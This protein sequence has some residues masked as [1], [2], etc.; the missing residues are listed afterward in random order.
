M[1]LAGA[2]TT[3]R[4]RF[5][6]TELWNGYREASAV[7]GTPDDWAATASGFCPGLRSRGDRRADWRGTLFCRDSTTNGFPRPG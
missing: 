2:S 4:P 7:T 6:S 1:Q 3:M 5:K